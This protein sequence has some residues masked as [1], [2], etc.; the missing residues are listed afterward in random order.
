MPTY[1]DEPWERDGRRRR[2][3]RHVAWRRRRSVLLFRFRSFLL[4]F[5]VVLLLS[6]LFT[7]QGR[8]W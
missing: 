1:R 5:V 2:G 4:V 7:G 8:A 3:E 6:L